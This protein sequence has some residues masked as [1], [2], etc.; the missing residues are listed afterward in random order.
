MTALAFQEP[1]QY[2]RCGATVIV[3]D[4]SQLQ[5]A[6]GWWDLPHSHCHC[7]Q[8]I[9]HSPYNRIMQ[10]QQQ[11]KG[12]ADSLL[13]ILELSDFFLRPAGCDYVR[14]ARAY[15]APETLP[16]GKLASTMPPGSSALSVRNRTLT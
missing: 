12:Y 11:K 7:T 13:I 14:T 1:V 15:F 2:A 3:G 6:K 9:P 5:A 16:P 4:A 10:Q 8:T